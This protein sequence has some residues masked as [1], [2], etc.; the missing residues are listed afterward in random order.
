MSSSAEE[1]TGFFLALAALAAL[2]VGGCYVS[3]D[4]AGPEVCNYKDD[5]CDGRIDEDFVDEQG[6]Y[7]LKAHCGGCGVDCD[8]V[9]PTAA[10][11]TCV[12]D[13]T[14]GTASC[15]IVACPEGWHLVGESVCAPDVPVLCLPCQTDEECALRVPGARCVLY[16]DRGRCGQPCEIESD[17]PIGFRCEGDE[18]P[19]CVA[20]S[21]ECACSEATLGAEL[22]CLFGEGNHVCAGVR[23]CGPDGFGECEPAV[24]EVCNGVDDNCDGRVDEGF[25]DAE[26]RYVDPLHCGGCNTPC[27]APGPNMAAVCVPNGPSPTDAECTV[28]CAEGFVDVDGI[29]A[30]GCECRITAREGPP[31]AIGGDADCDGVP[32]QGDEYVFVSTSGNDAWPGTL[33]QP[34]RTLAGGIDRARVLGR[35]VLVARGIY[36]GRVQVVGGVSL[37]GGYRPDFRDRDPALFPVILEHRQAPFGDPVLRCE[38]VRIATRIEGFQVQGTDA[39]AAGEGSTAIF[40]DGCGPEVELRSIIV[41]AGRG[42]DGTRGR[43]SSE[44]LADLGFGSLE[45]LRGVA[46]ANGGNPNLGVACGGRPGGTGGAKICLGADVGGGRGGDATCPNLGCTQGQP[47]ANAG[48]TDFTR[49]GVCDFAAMLAL[50]VPNPAASPGRGAAP[51]TPGDRTFNAPTN[52]VTCNFCDDNPTLRRDGADGTDGAPG[53]VGAGGSGCST[54]P[55][56]EEATGRLHGRTGASGA[57]GSN[58]SGGGGGTSGAG[59]AVIGGTEG[60]C[61]DRAGGSGGGGGSGGCGAPG[62]GGG[63]GGG[64]SVGIVVSIPDGLSAGPTLV[65]VRVV[66][67]SGGRGG[68]GG[69]GA[70]G[71]AGGA[72][73][74]GGRS[75]FWCAR[76]GGR[77]GDGG[78]GGSGGGGGGG[79]GGG[80][81]GVF[82]RRPGGT[83]LDA[84][85]QTLEAGVRVERAGV[86]GQG[87]AGG[88]SPGQP[89]TAGSPGSNAS[90]LVSP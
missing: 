55:I 88:Y 61:F 52:R 44:H 10:E 7:F 56:L 32:D 54:A 57:S 2:F 87:G 68:D 90:I 65:D 58:G 89:G 64:A 51:G 62:A 69:V 84:Y 40:L 21:G 11:T 34:K 9:F 4:C 30:N 75:D 23:V 66:T 41:L 37:Y 76:Q 67:A 86:P 70:A 22:A 26:G 24:A 82:V 6:L 48:C 31:V 43:S 3:R 63:G 50:A 42:A 27:I 29:L 28:D 74:I 1:R 16:G 12:A 85:R 49:N 15:R 25:V 35:D 80:S 14:S 71:G 18:A 33:E 72:G 13:R 47:C 46:G 79:C 78:R 81:H 73:G 8:A 39:Q 45:V 20:R 77:G 19:Q 53:V 59:Y 83:N 17:C 38:N 5:T 60:G 36:D